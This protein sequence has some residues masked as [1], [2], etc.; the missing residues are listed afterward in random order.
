[1]AVLGSMRVPF[2]GVRPKNLS[3][4]GFQREQVMVGR[5]S[6]KS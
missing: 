5:V 3:H 2:L 6:L 1:M 4:K